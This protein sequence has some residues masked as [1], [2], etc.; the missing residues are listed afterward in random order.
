PIAAAIV[1][2]VETT[3]TL[4]IDVTLTAN[5]ALPGVSVAINPG[6][7]PDVGPGETA[8]F[9]VTFTMEGWFPG[10]AVDLNFRDAASNAI[11]DTQPLTLGPSVCRTHLGCNWVDNMIELTANEPTFW[12]VLNG[13]PKGTSPFTILDPGFPPGRPDPDGS[14]DR[15]LR[16]F[17][18]AWAVDAT[19]VEIR[20]N[21]LKGDALLVDYRNGSAWEYNAYAFSANAGTQGMPTGTPGELNLDGVEYDYCFESLL[22]DFYADGSTPF[23]SAF[24][25]G[26]TAGG[27][28]P[29]TVFTDLTLVPMLIDLRQDGDGLVT[30]KAKF[31]I[32]NMNEWK[33]SGTERCIECWDQKFLGLYDP[34]NHFLRRNLQ[35]D[36]G[37]ARIIGMQSSV[38]PGSVDTPLLGVAMKMLRFGYKSQVGQAGMHLFGMG[39]DR[40]AV[41]TADLIGGP[42]PERSGEDA[43]IGIKRVN[44]RR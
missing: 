21:H 9:D 37:K 23:G 11:L 26:G 25:G 32:W 35:T 13:M 8:C 36:K 31:D 20:H 17:V 14:G 40:S 41:I 5:P 33:F 7:V 2:A 16:G 6:V 43:T 19:G 27:A 30:T 44:S 39:E 15:V 29:I 28:P 1:E 4:P 38:C 22:L 10:G 12:S 24:F 3:V 42:P 34:P 18:L